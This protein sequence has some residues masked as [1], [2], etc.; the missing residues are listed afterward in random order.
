MRAYT[1]TILAHCTQSSGGTLATDKEIIDWT[2]KKL[3]SSNKRSSLQSFQDPRI[4]DAKVVLDLID[5]IQPGVIDYSV[6]NDGN[7]NEV[8]DKKQNKTIF[9]R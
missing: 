4:S 1:L 7:T 2:N 8:G 5:A 3:K 9:T 6:V